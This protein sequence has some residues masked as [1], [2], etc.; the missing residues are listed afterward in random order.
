MKESDKCFGDIKK[1]EGLQEGLQ[2]VFEI[3]KNFLFY[4]LKASSHLK[5]IKTMLH[6]I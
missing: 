5:H 1:R 2:V 4:G 3:E 6:S